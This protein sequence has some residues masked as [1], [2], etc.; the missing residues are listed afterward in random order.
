MMPKTPRHGRRFSGNSLCQVIKVRSLNDQTHQNGI[1]KAFNFIAQNIDSFFIFFELFF[2][3]IHQKINFYEKGYL[4]T[5]G[6]DSPI[7]F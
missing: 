1:I 4:C 3:F 6:E 5:Q 7:V 2:I